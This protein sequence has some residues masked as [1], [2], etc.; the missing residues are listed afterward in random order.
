MGEMAR[1]TVV[2]AARNAV[3]TL[4]A[5]VASLAGQTYA[6][7]RAIVVDDASTDGTG[8]L[9]STLGERFCTVTNERRQGPGGSRNLG[10]QLASSELIAT[11]DADDLWKPT[12]LERQVQMYDEVRGRGKAVALVCCDAELIGADGDVR[13]HWSDRVA[14]PEGPVTLDDLLRENVVYNSVLASREVFLSNGGY[15]PSLTWGEDYD[16]WLRL[17]EQGHVL[18]SNPEPL[19]VYRMHPDAL[20]ADAVRISAGTRTVLERALDRGRLSR[21]QRAV[22]ARQRRLHSLLE[23]R[24]VASGGGI[25][26]RL[27]LAPALA[28]VAL[29][30]PER[31]MSWLRRG[32]RQAGEGR[33][34]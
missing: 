10:A 17:A 11:L 7:W 18:V 1:V 25:L 32:P 5:T 30:H 28:R 14:L 16:L 24:A 23:R 8:A 34:G 9:L 4:P 15:E 22:A 29:E 33:H 27:R 2:I 6:D 19:A 13:G 20:S 12:Y 21:R 31:W 26:A 3:Q